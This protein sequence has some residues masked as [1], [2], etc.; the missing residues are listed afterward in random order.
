MAYVFN[1]FAMKKISNAT[2]NVSG[3]VR[4]TLWELS[5]YFTDFDLFEAEFMGFFG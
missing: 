5:S 3:S 1:L 2:M 4:L